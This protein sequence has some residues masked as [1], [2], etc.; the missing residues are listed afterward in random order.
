MGKLE[1]STAKKS[2]LSCLTVSAALR[3][4][5]A[6][7]VKSFSL[8][9]VLDLTWTATKLPL[10]RQKMTKSGAMQL[11]GAMMTRKGDVPQ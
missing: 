8:S 4:F 5:F 1:P 2:M 7:S 10:S 3:R 9:R 11:A 6:C